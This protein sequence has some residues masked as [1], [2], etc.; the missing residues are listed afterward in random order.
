MAALGSLPAS[1]Q[2]SA[3]SSSSGAP[4]ILPNYARAQNYNS[5]KQ[6]SY[7]R[8][9]GNARFLADR[10][11]APRRNSSTPTGPGVITHIWFTIAAD[12]AII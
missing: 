12:S 9:G 6:S 11:R 1:A 4:V 10:S 5:L 3:A 7:D 8:T 2:A